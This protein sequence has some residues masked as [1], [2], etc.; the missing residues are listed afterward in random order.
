[1]GFEAVRALICDVDGTLTDGTIYLGAVG[2]EEV[3][4]KGFHAADGA[5]ITYL[6][7]CGVA[8]ALITGRTSALVAR[9][10]QELGVEQV[11]QGASP[12]EPA[13][14]E[15]MAALGVTDAEV[16]Y[17]GDDLADVPLL[18]RAGCGVAVGDARPEV[19]AAANYVTDAPGGRGAVREVAERI[20]KA[21][22]KWADVL[23]RYGL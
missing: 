20:L 15:L 5:G 17:V 2:G 9:R 10:A 8:V 23:R 3:E 16:C 22:G 12:K 1:V 11:R 18:H 21:Q 14:E 13:Y 19:R 4:L 7:R 6:L